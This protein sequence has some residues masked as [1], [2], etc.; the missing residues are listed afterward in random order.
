MRSTIQWLEKNRSGKKLELYKAFLEPKERALYDYLVG[1]GSLKVADVSQVIFGG[2]YKAFREAKDSLLDSIQDV[3][4]MTA[5]SASKRQQ[6]DN[7]VYYDAFKMMVFLRV[8]SAQSLIGFT[9][10]KNIYSIANHYRRLGLIPPALELMRVYRNRLISKERKTVEVERINGEI[11]ILL[12]S[13]YLRCRFDDFYHRLGSYLLNWDG[14]ISD[15]LTEID[16]LNQRVK[17]SLSRTPNAF[18]QVHF[19]MVQA[20]KLML[21]KM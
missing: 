9:E 13:F 17:K 21:E 5:R 16:S 18:L 3:T 2:S 7:Q 19:H 6:K 8:L 1:E 15:T 10:M 12:D 11:T 20:L 4:I 14:D